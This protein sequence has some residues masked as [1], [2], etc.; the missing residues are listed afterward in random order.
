ML[1]SCHIGQRFRAF[2]PAPTLPLLTPDEKAVSPPPPFSPSS[3]FE[4]ANS[5]GTSMSRTTGTMM[6]QYLRTKLG[7]S[8]AFSP[9]FRGVPSGFTTGA[10]GVGKLFRARRISNPSRTGTKFNLRK[11][12]LLLAQTYKHLLWLRREILCRATSCSERSSIQTCQ[13]IVDPNHSLSRNILVK[14]NDFIAIG[15]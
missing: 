10:A 9:G 5:V 8:G 13:I 11:R 1:S 14:G 15:R 12:I 7:S 3:L 4:S 2:D 6:Y